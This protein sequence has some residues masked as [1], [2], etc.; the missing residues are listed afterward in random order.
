MDK[1]IYGFRNR[2]KG[3][4]AKGGYGDMIS[5][6]CQSVLEG[7]ETGEIFFSN[8]G[9][10][11][12]VEPLFDNKME[13]AKDI[14]SIFDISDINLN[15][16][17]D[18]RTIKREFSRMCDVRYPLAKNRW[19]RKIHN[20]VCYHIHVYKPEE[21]T[22]NK[23]TRFHHQKKF[24]NAELEMIQER[25]NKETNIEFINIGDMRDTKKEA[26]II[27]N[28]DCFFGIESGMLHLCNCFEIPTFVQN[29]RPYSGSIYKNQ[30]VYTHHKGNEIN[31]FENAEDGLDKLFDYL[32]LSL[33][34]R[35]AFN[36]KIID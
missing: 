10:R 23:L 1:K 8:Y 32:S 12:C 3:R 30:T 28:S 20:R 25:F 22:R 33:E 16:V 11:D 34:D 29:Y 4:V 19:E 27:I 7:R 24:T 35:I 15:F 31:L 13:T 21:T 5:T 36:K 2:K 14:Y 18:P 17:K 9:D 26:D 6:I